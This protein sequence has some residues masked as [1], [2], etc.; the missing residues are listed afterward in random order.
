MKK[1]I[2]PLVSFPYHNAHSLKGNEAR[3]PDIWQKRRVGFGMFW[4]ESNA[5]ELLVVH[6]E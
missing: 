2:N 6:V 1:Y 4:E 5:I 3:I